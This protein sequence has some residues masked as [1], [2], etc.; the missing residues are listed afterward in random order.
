MC[1]VKGM[2][3]AC[4]VCDIC[5][6][7]AMACTSHSHSGSSKCAVMYRSSYSNPCADTALEGR[8]VVMKIVY[9]IAGNFH[10][11]G[12]QFYCKALLNSRMHNSI[13]TL[14][15]HTTFDGF[16]TRGMRSSAKQ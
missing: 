16:N 10:G 7:L 15:L 12:M 11:S 13:P 2:H 14:T 5:N 4:Y 8:L 1:L 6:G 3:A 9:Y